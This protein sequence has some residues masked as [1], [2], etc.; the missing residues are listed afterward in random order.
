[1]IAPASDHG[2]SYAGAALALGIK[3]YAGPQG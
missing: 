3:A 2:H 1:V